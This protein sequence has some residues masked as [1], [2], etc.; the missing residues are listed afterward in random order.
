MIHPPAKQAQD[1]AG[2]AGLLLIPLILAAG[3]SIVPPWPP[4]AAG[5]AQAPPVTKRIYLAPLG[6]F[7]AA[8]LERLLVYHREKHGLNFESLPQVEVER[9]SFDAFRR[10][11]IAEELVAL[12]KRHNPQQANDPAAILLGVTRGDM[13]IRSTDWRFAFAYREG[14]RFAVVS[15][16]RMDPSNFPRLPANPG[17]LE[18]RLRKMISKQIGIL[19]FGLPQSRDKRSVMY[20]PILSLADLDAIGEDF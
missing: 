11:L 1:G 14:E 10:Q 9:K 4:Q 19:V 8:S 16:A 2:K 7:P 15:S 20:G 12:M 17:L 3:A 5:Q 13:Y 6:P 18:L